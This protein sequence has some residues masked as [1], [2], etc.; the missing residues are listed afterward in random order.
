MPHY[1]FLIVYNKYGILNGS[2]SQSGIHGPEPVDP[3]P[4]SKKKLKL[5]IGPDQEKFEN[6]GPDRAGQGPTNF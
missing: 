3:G 4:T 5:W 2:D 1:Q 6:L